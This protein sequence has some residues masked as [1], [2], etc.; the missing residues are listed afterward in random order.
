MGQKVNPR[1][2]RIGTVL[3]WKN[4]WYTEPSNYLSKFYKNLNIKNLI[5]TFLLLKSER[6]L[7]VDFFIYDING[8]KSLLLISFYNLEDRKILKKKRTDFS[9][10]KY[11]VKKLK[12]INNKN[13]STKLYALK[14]NNQNISNFFNNNLNK[15][16]LLINFTNN[17]D[18]RANKFYM[19][20]FN[21]IY[22]ESKY[23]N[24][25][26]FY[27]GLHHQLN[28]ESKIINKSLNVKLL[29]LKLLN[30]L[31]STNIINK[32]LFNQ[33]Y[34]LN[35]FKFVNSFITKIYYQILK[36][37]LLYKIKQNK[38]SINNKSTLIFSKILLFNIKKLFKNL[39]LRKL[40]KKQGEFNNGIFLL[41]QLKLQLFN[42][43]TILKFKTNNLVKTFNL[44]N[45][46]SMLQIKEFNN[47]SN[48][49][50]Y[51]N[52]LIKTKKKSLLTFLKL[53]K[54]NFNDTKN[55]NNLILNNKLIQNY[56]NKT[57]SLFLANK[58]NLL[59]KNK[60]NNF[61]YTNLYQFKR[62]LNVLNKMN[63][64][65]FLYNIK[66]LFNFSKLN[67]LNNNSL[68]LQKQKINR[69]FDISR[70]LKKRFNKR[71]KRI[72]FLGSDLMNIAQYSL[73]FK[74]PTLLAYFIS[75]QFTFL[76]KN[77]RQTSFAKYVSKILFNFK[78]EFNDIQGLK[79]Q[80]KGRFN[81]WSR[82]KKWIAQAGTILLQ[83]YN[84]CVDYS[85]SKG[86]V[87]KGIFSTRIWIQY[88][89]N[90]KYKLKKNILKYFQYS[91][92]RQKFKK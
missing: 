84:S 61:K 20:K 91:Y 56:L 24:G 21:N 76:P 30:K 54:L 81:K 65:V 43:N 40:F 77:K 14:L 2:L 38:L 31:T 86:L 71:W 70:K 33:N 4:N 10:M 46:S 68:N 85:C 32:T 36:F 67:L 48:E 1:G 51:K 37:V 16:K 89:L 73:F 3:K 25:V 63:Y 57:D 74:N 28:I 5:K 45:N 64:K 9:L 59:N 58:P 49:S 47:L 41:T 75:Y 12:T 80:F 50:N 52:S 13:I 26:K 87:K 17:L 72:N 39:K 42:F 6:S 83:S 23:K 88:D 27:N 82:S 11:K 53:S 15:Y 34:I 8:Y 78:G 69:Y 7:L 62:I 79:L 44:L 18:K 55:I 90:T 66:S 22:I 19:A 92:I 29:N 60:L 35:S